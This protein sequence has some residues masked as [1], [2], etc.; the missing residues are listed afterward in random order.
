MSGTVAEALE[1]RV[2]QERDKLGLNEV[3]EVVEKAPVEIT[4]DLEI[5]L[6]DGS[7]VTIG[8]LKAAGLRQADYTRKTMD[9]ADKRKTF[10]AE[11][12]EYDEYVGAMN[13]YWQ[14]NPGDYNKMVTYFEKGDTVKAEQI[15]AKA[16]VNVE[17][18]NPE[19]V[20]QVRSPEYDQKLAQQDRELGKLK[21]QM[22]QDQVNQAIDKFMADKGLS[23]GDMDKVLEVAKDNLVPN[24]SAYENLQN[25]YRLYDYDNA[26]KKG[27]KTEE[28]RR[29]EKENAQYFG[30]GNQGG[31]KQK[32]EADLLKA[33]IFKK[34]RVNIL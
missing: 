3:E 32:S 6:K 10:E 34:D 14:N 11:K 15:Q 33:A 5:P 17:K 13:Y 31:S 16:E 25:A 2:E 18:K 12:T 23:E 7:K 24:K 20:K 1:A 21:T 4:D 27:Q 8:D 19:L 22:H 30:G 9:L 28:E 26:Y 29:L